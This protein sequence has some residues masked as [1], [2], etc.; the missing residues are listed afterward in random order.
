MWRI[1]PF[2]DSLYE[3]RKLLILATFP[4]ISIEELEFE[5]KRCQK[6]F[7]FGKRSYLCT[8][9]KQDKIINHK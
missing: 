2:L 7:Y 9:K 3:V 4:T 8:N 6:F 1:L 5:R